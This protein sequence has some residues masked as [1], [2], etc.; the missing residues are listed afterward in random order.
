MVRQAGE[1]GIALA[2]Q[3]PQLAPADG[4]M[5]AM[6]DA[7][8]AVESIPLIVSSI[9]SKKLACGAELVSLDVKCGSGAFMKDRASADALA[10]ALLETGR[11]C[12]LKTTAVVTDM[13]S[14]LGRT[15]GNAIEVKEAIRVL[16]GARG[17]FR[18]LCLMLARHTLEA[19]GKEA[20]EA[21]KALDDGRALAKARA[22]FDAQGGD[23]GVFDD[24]SLLPAAPC[25]SLGLASSGGTVLD[26]D[27]GAVGC[28]CVRLGAGREKKGDKIDP[29]AGVEFAVDVGYSV[30]RGDPLFRVDG[31]NSAATGEAVAQILAA[32]T[33]G[34]L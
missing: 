9:L 16:N 14:P 31:P 7:I 27:A 25:H 32:I 19:S 3:S 34:T 1:V 33:V 24:E 18:D 21:E 10:A 4:V 8:G 15:V 26:I 13:S 6:R 5:Y 2:E 22:W 30:D 20:A 11:R 17:R 23:A 12:G 29:S 28:A